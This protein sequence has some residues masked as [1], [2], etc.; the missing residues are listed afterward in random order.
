MLASWL[1][2]ANSRLAVISPSGG[3]LFAKQ[4][5]CDCSGYVSVLYFVLMRRERT[6]GRWVCH[7]A[8][9]PCSRLQRAAAAARRCG[10][11]TLSQ[12]GHLVQVCVWHHWYCQWQTERERGLVGRVGGRVSRETKKELTVW[13]PRGLV[14]LPPP[15]ESVVTGRI[16]HT[17]PGS[18]RPCRRYRV[19]FCYWVVVVVF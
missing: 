6:G 13:I 1:M 18:A 10:A 9:P 14:L 8:A 11:A 4:V 5:D 17:A 7:S 12:S 3:S 19:F 2:K 15:E 16:F